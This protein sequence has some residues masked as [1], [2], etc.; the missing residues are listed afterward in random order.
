MPCL[1]LGEGGGYMTVQPP[2][3]PGSLERVKVLTSSLMS[4]IAKKFP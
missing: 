4:C 3:V 2:S 1:S